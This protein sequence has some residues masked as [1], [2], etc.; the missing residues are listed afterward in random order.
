MPVV[1]SINIIQDISKLVGNS[2]TFAK[3]PHHHELPQFHVGCCL[4]GP[5]QLGCLKGNG[6]NMENPLK[7]NRDY[8]WLSWFSTKIARIWGVLHFHTQILRKNSA[9][10]KKRKLQAAGWQFLRRELISWCHPLEVESH[11]VRC[12]KLKMGYTKCDVS[13]SFVL[14]KRINV[15]QN[16]RCSGPFIVDFP[17]KTSIYSGFSHKNIHL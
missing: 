3:S 7:S 4:P 10:G 15:Y 6:K 5:P 13:S 9:Y 8:L 2:R 1:K 11:K 16:I 12:G 17:T 14:S